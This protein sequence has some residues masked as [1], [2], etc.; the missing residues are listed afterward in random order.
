MHG[1]NAKQNPPREKH[2][3]FFFVF[4]AYELPNESSRSPRRVGDGAHVRLI[5]SRCNDA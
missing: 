1:M 2:W 5:E 4:M 3:I